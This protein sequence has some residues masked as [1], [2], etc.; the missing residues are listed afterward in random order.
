[1]CPLLSPCAMVANTSVMGGE[2]PNTR[3][4]DGA[5]EGGACEGGGGEGGRDCTGGGGS[6]G[7]DGRG[8]GGKGGRGEGGGGGGNGGWEATT[9]GSGEGE[10]GGRDSGGDGGRNGGGGDDTRVELLTFTPCKSGI[11]GS[12]TQPI[13]NSTPTMALMAPTPLPTCFIWAAHQHVYPRK[14][15]KEHYATPNNPPRLPNPHGHLPRIGCRYT[16]SRRLRTLV[17]HTSPSG[18][19]LMR[20]VPCVGQVRRSTS[21]GQPN[22]HLHAANISYC[23]V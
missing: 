20:R 1:M 9:G 11:T 13:T 17:V 6:S 15:G 21:A 14:R 8:D 18:V 2:G 23:H 12:S 4:G 7:G 5:G 10:G 22:A 3:A 19:R 16:P